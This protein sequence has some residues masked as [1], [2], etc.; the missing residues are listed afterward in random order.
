MYVN[1]HEH[2][3]TAMPIV[4]HS[5]KTKRPT[6]IFEKGE[7]APLCAA[8][9]RVDT[10]DIMEYSHFSMAN[11]VA[12]LS[13]WVDAG[14]NRAV[15]ESTPELAPLLPHLDSLYRQLGQIRG[16]L[17]KL[18]PKMRLLSRKIRQLD[19]IHNK[20][21]RGLYNVLTDLMLL[22]DD[23]ALAADLC[24]V[25]DT[26]FPEDAIGVGGRHRKPT[27]CRMAAEPEVTDFMRKLLADTA[28]NGRTLLKDFEDWIATCRELGY[29]DLE[30]RTRSENG[31]VP[32]VTREDTRNA[33]L[34][35]N[36]LVKTVVSLLDIAS[37]VADETK[38]RLLEPL[39]CAE[40][41]TLRQP[42]EPP[43]LND[44]DLNVAAAMSAIEAT[45]RN[46]PANLL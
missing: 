31:Q 33:R 19:C 16:E 5:H 10:E 9:P 2:R 22:T 38:S 6:P 21:S 20:K 23:S 3:A 4:N 42:K 26:L 11:M 34:R 46:T 28:Y 14:K 40:A 30:Q 27:G 7:I 18:T 12:V 17:S 45:Q 39:R 24:H 43:L 44:D 25:R 15:F 37:S 1:L 32:T 41:S 35:W 29:L 13:S 8:L 36:R